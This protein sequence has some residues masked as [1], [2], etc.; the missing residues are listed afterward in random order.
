MKPIIK[1]AVIGGTDKSGKYLVKKLLN[2]EHKPS[3]P[4]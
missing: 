2:Q 3:F 4:V 1:V